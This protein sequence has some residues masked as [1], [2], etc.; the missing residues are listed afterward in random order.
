VFGYYIEISAAAMAAAEKER[1]A[2]GGTST[3]LPEDY[4]ARQSLAN[5]TRYVTARLKEAETRVLGAQEILAH[6]EA[7]LIKRIVAEVAVHVRELCTAA[8]AI[9]YIDVVATLADVAAARGYVRPIV[10][11][12]LTI[13][14]VDGRHPHSRDASIPRRVHCQRLAA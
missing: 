13:E 9:A 1:S 4:L 11:D 7:D 6:L 12:S 10:D 8:A 14:I 2:S 3:V 5:G